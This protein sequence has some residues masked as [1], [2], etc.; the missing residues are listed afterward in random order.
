M[1]KKLLFI[2]VLAVSAASVFAQNAPAP[3][4]YEICPQ[5]IGALSNL[6]GASLDAYFTVAAY[7]FTFTNEFA[8]INFNSSN[9]V[10]QE[11]YAQL[12]PTRGQSRLRC[13]SRRCNDELHEQPQHFHRNRVSGPGYEQLLRTTGPQESGDLS[14]F[15][16][17]VPDCGR[18]RAPSDIDYLPFSSKVAKTFA[19]GFRDCDGILDLHVTDLGVKEIRLDRQHHSLL[20]GP[21]G[22][23]RKRGLLVGNHAY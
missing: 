4:K 3:T 17:P 18:G 12:T 10:A 11:Y 14:L 22:L 8:W 21:G 5:R 13:T 1:M 6:S 16:K 7:G 19:A 2:C 23:A 15:L 9:T 20:K